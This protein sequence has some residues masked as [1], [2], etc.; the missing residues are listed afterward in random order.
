VPAV[1]F[2]HDPSID[3]QLNLITCYGKFNYQSGQY[4][5]RSIVVSKLTGD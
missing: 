5:E 4:D 1:L 2:A 3:S